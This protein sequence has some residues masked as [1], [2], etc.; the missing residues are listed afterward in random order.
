MFGRFA[1]LAGFSIALSLF[2]A[3]DGSGPAASARPD[4]ATSGLQARAFVEAM[5]P[6]R[7]GRP[8]VAVLALNDGTEMSDL[9]LPYALLTRADVADV[10]IVAPRAGRVDLYPALQIDGAQALADFDRL[11]PL[12]A[13]YVIVPA[14]SR[15]D[16]PELLA[17]LRRQVDAGARIIGVCVGARV[18]GQAGLLDGRRFT[19]H[20][21][22]RRTL[23][24]HP[25][26]TWVPDQRY[27]VDR[28]VATTT[29]ISASVPTMLA[30][31]EALGGG[32]RAQALAADLGVESWDPSHDSARFGLGA[33]HAWTYVADELAFWRD[34]T[35]RVEVRDGIDDVA[36]ALVVDAWSRTGRVQVVAA[37]DAASVVL[38]SG[39]RLVA[40]DSVDEQ[41]P[42]IALEPALAPVRQLDRT[43]TQIAERFGETRRDRVMQEM[44]YP[45][46]R[47]TS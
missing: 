42:R 27:I 15:D 46:G 37:S 23:L 11:H 7:P 12:G 20:W 44:E 28:G 14:M 29:G 13:D 25:G 1:A 43:L 19:G 9:L 3:C 5:Q 10:R 41:M 33:R 34:E 22:D 36:L 39:L 6:V 31:V 45:G 2:A 8:V 38:R 17:W 4:P 16:D 21:Y 40:A 47:P 35:W 24:R 18:L 26:A 32:E 30:L